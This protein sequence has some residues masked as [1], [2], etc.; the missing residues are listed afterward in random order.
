MFWLDFTLSFYKNVLD[1]TRKSCNTKF[2]PQRKE[3]SFW[4]EGWALGYNFMKF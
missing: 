2:G 1:Q 3:F 4:E